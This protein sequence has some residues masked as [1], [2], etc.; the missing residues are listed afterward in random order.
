VV[1][2]MPARFRSIPPADVWTA[3]HPS[4]RND[5][6]NFD[7][8]GRLKPGVTMAHAQSQLDAVREAFLRQLPRSPEDDA[9]PR[10]QP[11]QSWLTS[12][13]RPALLLLLGAVGI[14]LLIACAN[15]ASLLLA[16]AS[17]RS[18]EF[19]IR[20]ALGARRGRIIRQLLT[21]SAL[22]ALTGGGLGLMLA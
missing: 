15:T 14:V 5:A 1:G 11:H 7:V 18:R 12:K 19:A 3:L 9:V 22:L 4:P 8:V 2:I 17:S 10:I 16:R 20:A 21:E 6:P 13:M